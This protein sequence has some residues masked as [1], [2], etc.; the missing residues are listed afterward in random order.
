MAQSGTASWL[1]GSGLDAGWEADLALHVKRKKGRKC[2]GTEEEGIGNEYLDTL[3]FTKV[4]SS[5]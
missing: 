5:L 4:K 2:E 1:A 3:L